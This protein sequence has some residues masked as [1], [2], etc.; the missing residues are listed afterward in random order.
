MQSINDNNIEADDWIRCNSTAEQREYW[1]NQRN[2]ISFWC[3][4]TIVKNMN[5]IDDK[6]AIIVP[7][8]DNQP[9]QKRKEQ[10]NKFIPEITKFLLMAEIPFKIFIIEQSNDKRKFNRGKLLNVG[11][12]LAASL[13]YTIFVLHGE[14]SSLSF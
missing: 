13:G 12:V 8:R 7:F 5:E 10:L 1:F 2:G 4:D 14:Y 3:N 9:Q 6:V 11:Y